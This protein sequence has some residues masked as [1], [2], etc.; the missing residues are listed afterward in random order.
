MTRGMSVAER[1][2]LRETCRERAF[3]DAERKAATAGLT[4]RCE[5]ALDMEGA[6]PALVRGEHQACRGEDRGG[7]GC[8][9]ICHDNPGAAAE[10]VSR[11]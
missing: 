2:E 9:C 5:R 11:G 6:S 3:A 7:V 1:R 4:L 10:E 8:L